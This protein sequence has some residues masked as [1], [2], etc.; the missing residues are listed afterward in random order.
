MKLNNFPIFAILIISLFSC[1]KKVEN[2]KEGDIIFQT[3]RSK[4]SPLIALATL[5][6]KTHCGIIVE[7][8]NKLYVL[9]PAARF[10]LLLSTS[11]LQKGK[12]VPIK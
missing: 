7:K 4:Q 11:L 8:N 3:S 9:E 5:S 2:F 10:V 12:M 6:N 1:T